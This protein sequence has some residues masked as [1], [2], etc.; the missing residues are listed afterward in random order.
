MGWPVTNLPLTRGQAFFGFTAIYWLIKVVSP[1][2]L[3]VLSLTSLYVAPL[4]ISP[5]GCEVAHDARV[6]AEELAKPVVDDGKARAHGSETKAAAQFSKM[7]ESAMDTERR[8]GD[9]AHS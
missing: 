9:I 5:R 7:H 4:V 1:F 2:S 8:I 6:R 3:F